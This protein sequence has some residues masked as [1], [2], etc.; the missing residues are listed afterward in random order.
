MTILAVFS[1]WLWLWAAPVLF[2][3]HALNL[4]DT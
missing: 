2:L 4:Q 1:L 3:E